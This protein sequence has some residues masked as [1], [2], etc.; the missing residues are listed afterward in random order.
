MTPKP[1]APP[2]PLPLR[3]PDVDP[4]VLAD[5]DRES[6]ATMRRGPWQFYLR[7]VLPPKGDRPAD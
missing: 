5:E 1:V 7:R 3:F 4:A 2:F 6:A